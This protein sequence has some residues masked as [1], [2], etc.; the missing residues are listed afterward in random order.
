MFDILLLVALR[1]GRV[2]LG[3][4]TCP[5]PSQN[6]SVCC[7]LGTLQAGLHQVPLPLV[8]RKLNENPTHRVAFVFFFFSWV[9]FFLLGGVGNT[10]PFAAQVCSRL[11]AAKQN[12]VGRVRAGA[13]AQG[14]GGGDREFKAVA[15][16]NPFKTQTLSERPKAKLGGSKR[17]ANLLRECPDSQLVQ[18]ML[19]GSQCP[20]RAPLETNPYNP[21]S[22]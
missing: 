14:V 16:R 10:N 5:P 7:R 22:G 18:R 17:S 19:K 8:F 21:C 20:W 9:L 11:R 12:A 3:L 4:I 2:V 1:R 13:E 15:W 6:P